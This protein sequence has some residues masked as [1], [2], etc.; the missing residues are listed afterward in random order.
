MRHHIARLDQL[1]ALCI[2][3]QSSD[4]SG[5]RTDAGAQL[6]GLCRQVQADRPGNASR[7]ALENV[8]DGRITA[9]QSH[10]HQRPAQMQMRVMLPGKANTAVHLDVE[11]GIACIGRKRQG[12][13]D[14]G[15]QPKLL[16]ILCCRTRGIPDRGD[17]R[18]GGH[19][20]VRAVMLHRLKRGDGTAELLSHLG[21]GHGAVHAVGRPTDGLG[22]QQCARAGQSRFIRTKQDV[23]GRDAHVV[24]A[25]A[26]TPPGRIKVFR[27]INRDALAAAFQHQHVVT[28]GNQQQ[29]GK[30]GAQH[31]S[32]LTVGNTVG[33]LHLTIQSHTRRQGSVNQRR[34]QPCPLVISTFFGDHR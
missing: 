34:Q 22:G 3:F 10:G 33:N 18:L 19:Q 28:G 12:R 21:I 13:S 24:Q 11:L 20:H 31:D 26:A 32:H 1:V 17:R 9:E 6:L 5:V 27:H 2:L 8:S 25:H 14:R 29:L 16:L 23:V 4:F 7:G 15:G 30:P